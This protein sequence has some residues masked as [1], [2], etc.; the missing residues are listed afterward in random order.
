MSARKTEVQL[1]VRKGLK[2]GGRDWGRKGQRRGGRWTL[3]GK[4]YERRKMDREGQEPI[5]LGNVSG[6]GKE[7]TQGSHRE[8]AV[9]K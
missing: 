4:L 6:T 2:W 1:F 7:G 9:G 5:S 3:G 8:C